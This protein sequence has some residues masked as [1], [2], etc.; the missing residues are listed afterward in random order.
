[1]LQR[2]KRNEQI[3]RFIRRRRLFRSI[4]QVRPVLRKTLSIKRKAIV[5]QQPV[6]R[7]SI[8]LPVLVTSFQPKPK[9][10]RKEQ[11]IGRVDSNRRTSVLSSGVISQVKRI[12]KFN[13]V[14]IEIKIPEQ[15]IKHNP[16]PIKLESK[17]IDIP[18]KYHLLSIQGKMD[19]FSKNLR[20][21]VG[22]T[23]YAN[24]N[25][26]WITE[27]KW[28]T[29]LERQFNIENQS[30]AWKTIVSE[31]IPTAFIRD[32]SLKFSN[33]DIDK[34]HY[35]FYELD[36]LQLTYDIGCIHFTTSHPPKKSFPG[37]AI[38]IPSIIDHLRS[39]IISLQG[40][41]KLKEFNKPNFLETPNLSIYTFNLM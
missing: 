17:V 5:W 31:R 29:Q 30:E 2:Q 16:E 9:P 23:V 26:K 41:Q 28:P 18:L 10:E 12:Q 19:L 15:P 22:P 32:P 34:I 3:R 27:T 21:H 7:G 14:E 24:Q 37:L 20:F 4:R 11:F 40:A 13:P 35:M 36:R 33:E 39:Y 6:N 38:S 1:M 25:T 8:S